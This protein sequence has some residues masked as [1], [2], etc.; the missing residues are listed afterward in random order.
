M[1]TPL[2]V[3]CRS[4]WQN[5][6]E[7]RSG[8]GAIDRFDCSGLPESLSKVAGEV[9]CGESSRGLFDPEEF[10]SEKKDV[11]KADRF[12]WYG[13]GAAAE[14]VADSGWRPTNEEELSRTGVIVGS[15]IGGLESIQNTGEIIVEKGVRRISPFFI[16]ES[17]INLVAGHISIRYGFTGPNLSMVTAC[18]TG[19]HALGE[20]AEIIARDDA[21]VMVAGGAEAP[22]CLMGVG[23]FSSMHALSTKFNGEPERASRPWD[24]DRDGFVISEGAGILVLEE[25]EH[26]RRRGA[27]IYCEVVGYGL[28]GDAFHVTA[29]DAQGRGA[30]RSMAMALRSGG[31]NP[32]DID[33]INAHGTSTPIGDRVEFSA[34][35]ELFGGKGDV[36]MS[37]TK[38][39]LGHMLGAAGSTE[40]IFLILAIRDGVVPPTL[41][42]D[43]VDEECRG[44]DLVPW[45][46]RRREVRFAMSNS[47]GFGGTNATVIMRKI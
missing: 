21:D 32:E 18:S 22:I 44:I 28:S 1:V 26:A 20:A 23:G 14:A 15:G 10:F 47:F 9:K 34:V 46:A 39:A 19:A 2:G 36:L 43:N 30:K 3:D 31:L 17:L 5:L 24:R 41:N 40:S 37:S 13:L 27:N 25:Y 38:S 33:Y 35:R 16:P 4:T 8:L 6:L 42:L 12:I 45:E 29:P 11:R 7:G